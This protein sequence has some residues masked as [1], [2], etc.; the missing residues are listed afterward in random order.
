M[1]TE[2]CSLSFSRCHLLPSSRTHDSVS[3]PQPDRPL[4]SF[5]PNSN[6]APSSEHQRPESEDLDE[7]RSTTQALGGRAA[8]KLQPGSRGPQHPAPPEPLVTHRASP[9]SEPGPV[10][11]WWPECSGTHVLLSGRLGASAPLSAAAP[12]W[13]PRGWAFPRGRAPAWQRAGV[14]PRPPGG[15]KAAVDRIQR[16]D[17]APPAPAVS[18]QGAKEARDRFLRWWAVP[19]SP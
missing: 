9:A 16:R 6:P 13:E 12:A 3:G 2:G 5:L 15:G 10:R 1:D 17:A 18:T 19:V 11:P 8:L 4:S 7:E 14:G